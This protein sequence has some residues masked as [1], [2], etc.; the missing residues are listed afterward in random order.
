MKIEDKVYQTIKRYSL[1]EKGDR[2]LIGISGGPDSIT[3]LD[4]LYRLRQKLRFSLFLCHLDHGIRKESGKDALFVQETAHQYKTPLFLKRVKLVKRG[5]LEDLARGVR[6]RFYESAA[7]EAKANKVALGHNLDDQAETVLLHLIRGTGIQGLG[8]MRFIRKIREKSQLLVIRPLLEISRKEI[9]SY[10]KKR[11]ISYLTDRTNLDKRFLRNRVR[12]ELIP[13][14]TKYNPAVKRKLSEMGK[15]FQEDY[16]YI[17]R[18]AFLLFSKIG[19]EEKGKVC[20][21]LKKF[22]KEPISLQREVLRQIIS[23]LFSSR[24]ACLAMRRPQ[25]SQLLKGGY[26]PPFSKIESLLSFISSPR[27]NTSFLLGKG[28]IVKKERHFLIFPHP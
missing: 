19:K 11:E 8:G 12:L 1:I 4:L 17:Q 18:N 20:F 9:L 21:D 15:I 14:L 13:L 7:K 5:S 10:L 26:R 24:K 3:L 16:D 23:F 2:V 25:G 28:L 6:Y 22:S 27:G